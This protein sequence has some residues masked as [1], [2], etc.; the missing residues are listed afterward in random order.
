MS[1][2]LKKVHNSGGKPAFPLE[3]AQFCLATCWAPKLRNPASQASS[4]KLRNSS[5]QGCSAQELHNPRKQSAALP[6]NYTNLL[7][8]QPNSHP[9][10]HIFFQQLSSLLHV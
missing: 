7:G 6:R 8:N 10:M 4:R 1:R 5:W 3:I 9:E 2:S